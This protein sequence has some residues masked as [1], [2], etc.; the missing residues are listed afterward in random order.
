[1]SASQLQP[2]DRDLLLGLFESRLMRLDHAAELYFNGKRE[3]AKKRL[4][5]LKADRFVGEKPRKA[6]EPS[7]LFLTAQ[8]LR[9]LKEQGLLAPFGNLSSSTMQKRLDVSPFTVAHELVVMD[10]KVAFT[11]AFRSAG[12]SITEFSTWP[13]LNEFE[14]PSSPH[15]SSRNI[16][17]RP[18]GYLRVD[19]QSPEGRFEHVCYLEVDRSTETQSTLA[20]RASCYLTHYSSGGYAKSRGAKREEFKKFPFRVLFVFNND[21]RRNNFFAHCLQMRDPVRT[22]AWAT[23][24]AE[25]LSDPLGPIWLRPLDYENAV[26]NTRFEASRHPFNHVYRREPEREALVEK[27]APQHSFFG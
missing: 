21:E 2:R 15:L 7:I 22:I 13:L 5:K 18:D 9:Y 19:E 23:T 4:Q 16:V 14:V 26:R 20:L 12:A 27:N 3:A 17:V 24:Q 8:G 1:M 10:V 11:K 6:N 25:V